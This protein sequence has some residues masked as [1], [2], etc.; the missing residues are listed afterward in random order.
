MPLIQIEQNNPKTLERARFQIRSIVRATDK[1]TMNFMWTWAAGFFMALELED[2]IDADTKRLLDAEADQARDA[3]VTPD[4][5][6]ASQ[7]AQLEV[8]AV[9]RNES[10]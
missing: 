2:L 5:P 4:N 10:P 1:Q 6:Q 3:W 8:D 7:A 9:T